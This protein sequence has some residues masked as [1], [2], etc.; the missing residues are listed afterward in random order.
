MAIADA[1]LSTRAPQSQDVVH[2][3]EALKVM[4]AEQHQRIV[5]LESKRPSH[6]IRVHEPTE[7]PSR[8]DLLRRAGR[9]GVA[10]AGA[11]GGMALLSPGVAA[12]QGTA[13]LAGVTNDETATTVIKPA[14]GAIVSPALEATSA[15]SFASASLALRATAALETDT[16][17]EVN[18]DPAS[19]TSAAVGIYAHTSD[20]VAVLAKSSNGFAITAQAS[21]AGGIGV[22]AYAGGRAPVSITPAGAAG[23]PTTNAHFLGDIWTDSNGQLWV[24]VTSGTPG[25]FAPLQTGGANVSHFVRVTKAQYFLANSDGS[26]WA[27]MDPTGLSLTLTPLFN[28]Q[29]VISVSVDLWTA[30]AGLNQ[31]VGIYIEGGAYGGAG[32][33]K[34]VAWKESGGFAG[35]YSPNAAYV[36]TSQPLVAG[37]AYTLKVRWKTNKPAGGGV[38]FA[39]AGGA[40][41]YSPTRLAVNLIQDG[42]NPTTLHGPV[43]AFRN[44]PSKLPA[45][46]KK[47]A[48]RTG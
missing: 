3:I 19:T 36:E 23:P 18:A 44:D 38:I 43:A 45:A 9:V 33:G 39:A 29:S 32:A 30:K 24:C 15:G 42:P 12:T 46:P 35:T 21:A 27:D 10:A 40:G 7:Q 34:I 22:V 11:V 13:V 31:D 16:G 41:D 1:D 6:L 5:E 48:L 20:G 26:T 28:A 37:T 47:N 8:R 17:L 4:I 14:V 25:V 2:Q